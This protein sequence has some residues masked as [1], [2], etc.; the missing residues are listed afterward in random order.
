MRGRRRQREHG[1]VMLATLS[2]FI[3]LTVMIAAVLKG[4]VTRRRHLRSRQDQMVARCLAESGAHQAIHALTTGRGDVSLL[5]R[6]VGRGRFEASWRELE[7]ASGAYEI[8]SLGVSRPRNPSSARRIVRVRVELGPRSGSAG[9]EVH[10]R[11]WG[12]E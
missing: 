1:M 5:A 6:A 9:A 7:G 3:F 12:L 11:S 8:V 2:L 4:N 10:V